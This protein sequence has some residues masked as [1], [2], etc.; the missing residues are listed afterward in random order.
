M[1]PRGWVV[2]GGHYN[3]STLAVETQWAEAAAAE[4]EVNIYL[5]G[6]DG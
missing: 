1:L 5:D 2:T 4:G 6:P 3:I